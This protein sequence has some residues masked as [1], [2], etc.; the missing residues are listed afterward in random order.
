MA[1]ST[2]CPP[3]SGV[4]R[5]WSAFRR[6]TSLCVVE[7][8]EGVAE[9]AISHPPDLFDE[10]VRRGMCGAFRAA[11]VAAGARDVSGEVVDVAERET[12]VRVRWR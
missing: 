7:R 4:E 9:L 2:R 6:G 10:T 12:R 11:S 8:A 1:R 3:S 5:R